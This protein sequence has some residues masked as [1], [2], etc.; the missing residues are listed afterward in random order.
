MCSKGFVAAL[1]TALS[2]LLLTAPSAS[3]LTK[4]TGSGVERANGV[5]VGKAKCDRGEQVVSGGFAMP[6]E[7]EAVVNK[8]KGDRTWIV[9]GQDTDGPLTV[10]A[11]C[12]RHLTPGAESDTGR[13]SSNPESE[14]GTAKARCARAGP[15]WPA[16]GSSR[17]PPATSQSSRALAAAA[18]RG[19]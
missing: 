8:R 11:Y 4:E 12:S 1:G 15:R 17:R 2:L 9:K 16:A 3:A 7:S 14:E 5:W 10:Y 19:S 13:I 18:A 6:I